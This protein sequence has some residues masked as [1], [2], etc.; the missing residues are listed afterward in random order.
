MLIRDEKKL[1]EALEALENAERGGPNALYWI[2][3]AKGRINETLTSPM[4]KR[5]EAKA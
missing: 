5:V 2:G 4:R 3:I 1:Q